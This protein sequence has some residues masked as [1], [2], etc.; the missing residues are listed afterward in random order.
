M[1]FIPTIYTTLRVFYLGNL[2]NDYSYSIAGQLSW[3]NLFY[4]II[5]ES[6]IL[7]LYY[8]LGQVVSNKNEFTNRVKTGLKLVG[9]VYLLAFFI[10]CLW[11]K[12]LLNVMATNQLIIDESA[13]YIR[14]EAFANIFI[15]LFQFSLISLLVLGK[16]RLVYLIT[17]IKLLLYVLLDYFLVSNMSFLLNLGVNSIAISNI[18]VNVILFIIALYMLFINGVN[19]VDHK[20]SDYRWFKELARVGFLSGVESFVRNTAYIVM[21]SRMINIVNE[22]GVYWVANSFI[23]GWLLLPITQLGE[24]IKQEI[25][26]DVKNIKNN[27]VGYFAITVI[28]IVAWFVL[29]PLYKPFMQYVLN[30]NDVDRLYK[31][32]MISLGF[33]VLFAIQ[34]VFDST[35]YGLGKTH[36]MLFESVITNTIYYGASFILYLMGYWQPTLISIVLLFGIGNVF[37]TIVSLGAYLF[38]LKKND[39]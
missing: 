25:S 6:I 4:E 26:I 36:Y 32:V 33:Y 20:K 29:I 22:Q 10:I 14:L 12:P 1:G 38:L 15:I 11:I 9:V 30:Y 27:T 21:I 23:W 18:I 35:F 2:P 13:N 5:N 16:V 24:L 31:V 28:V 7:P 3:V 17:L 34:N 8:F 19:V 39:Y 37:D